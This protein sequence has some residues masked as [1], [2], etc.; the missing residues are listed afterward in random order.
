MHFLHLCSNLLPVTS[1]K[2]IYILKFGWFFFQFPNL[3]LHADSLRQQGE[4]KSSLF[5]KSITCLE[6]RFHQNIRLLILEKRKNYR[7]KKEKATNYLTLNRK[8]DLDLLVFN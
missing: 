4:T 6:V 7:E 2:H 1:R 8:Q 3:G 5:V